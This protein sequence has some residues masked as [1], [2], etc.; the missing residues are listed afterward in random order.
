M[1]PRQHGTSKSVS[2]HVKRAIH[3]CF[4]ACG[5]DVRSVKKLDSALGDLEK[6]RL[7]ERLSWLKDMEIRN[8]LDIGANEGQFAREIRRILPDAHISSFEP[9]RETYEKLAKEFKDV[10]QVDVYQYAIGERNGNVLINRNDFSPTSSI[11]PISRQQKRE[12]VSRFPQIVNQ[13]VPEMSAIRTLDDVVEE[14]KVS[15]PY[16]IKIDTEGYE[17]HVINGG[18]KTISGAAIAILETSFYRLYN[19]Q[20]LF[21]DIHDMMAELGFYYAGSLASGYS[22]VDG[23]PLQQDSIFLPPGYREARVNQFAAT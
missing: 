23:L 4:R 1:N 8:V 17:A 15:A 19:G 10:H 22:P 20:S 3:R 18:R 6:E 9:I 13:T 11:L 14:L 16:L 5:F 7:L 2:A 21:S 12:F